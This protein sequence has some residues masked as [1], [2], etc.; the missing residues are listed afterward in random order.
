VNS[1]AAAII[2]QLGLA[3]LPQEGGFFRQTWLAREKLSD[4]RVTGGAIY[5]LMTPADFSALHR[6]QIDELWHFYA[7]DAIEHVQLGPPADACVVTTLGPD[8]PGGQI[9]QLTV[10]A[11]VWQGARLVPGGPRGWALVG[12]TTSPAWIETD[13]E[14]GERESLLRHFPAHGTLIAGLTR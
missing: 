3:P 10:S 9:P 1:E 2:A 14:L 12:T 8:L 5:F 13:F 4:G 6:L 11:G 7:G